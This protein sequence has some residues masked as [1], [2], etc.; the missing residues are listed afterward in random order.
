MSLKENIL[1]E[2]F[3]KTLSPSTYRRFK[4]ENKVFPDV[5]YKTIISFLVGN[6]SI[7]C[8]IPPKY[9]NLTRGLK[10]NFFTC[11]AIKNSNFKV[12]TIR[13]SFYH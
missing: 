9:F 6:E 13:I 8:Y 1:K 2:N 11:Q 7:L 4:S 5:S 10:R 12:K 3:D